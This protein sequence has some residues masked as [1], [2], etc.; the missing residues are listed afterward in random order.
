M[1]AAMFIDHPKYSALLLRRTFADLSLPN[2]IMSRSKEWW[3][4]KAN[5]NDRDKTWTFPSGATITFGYLENEN[6]KYRYQGAEFQFIGFDELTQFRET[7]YRYLFSRLRRNNDN[8]VPL[9]MRSASNPGGVGHDWVKKRFVKGESLFIPALI[10]DNP[11]LNEEDYK[12]SLAELDPKTRKELLEGIWDAE[13][14]GRI[15]REWFRYYSR[16]DDI[17]DCGDI[18]YNEWQ[19]KNRFATVDH[20]NTVKRSAKDDPDYTVIAS[21]GVDPQDRLILL[22]VLRFRAEAPDIPVQIANEYEKWGLDKVYI[23]SGGTQTLHQWVRKQKLTSGRFMNVIPL[24]PRGDKL[25]RATAAINMIESGRI[26]FNKDAY[27]LEDF[28]AELVLFTG[29]EKID[30]HDDQVDALGIAG[31]V[32]KNAE[33]QYASKNKSPLFRKNF[34]I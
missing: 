30:I 23:E 5:W 25:E 7:Q 12:K 32:H 18:K 29:N 11:S 24:T 10:Q 16:L 19:I 3:M 20:A 14:T 9:R 33:R 4:G 22:N 34:K 15:R 17:F 26:L 8:P 1:A 13:D 31:N 21:W 6:D 2:A 28:E 27:W